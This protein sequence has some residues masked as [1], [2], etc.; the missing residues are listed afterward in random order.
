[1]VLYSVVGKIS[2]GRWG[3]TMEEPRLEGRN[4]VSDT[5]EKRNFIV[6][7]IVRLKSSEEI[8]GAY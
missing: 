5:R 7:I 4:H 3:N 8:L 6:R 1:M 2:F